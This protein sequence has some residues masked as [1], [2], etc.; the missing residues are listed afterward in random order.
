MFYKMF[1][2]ED[3]RSSLSEY[4]ALSILEWDVLVAS[5]RSFEQLFHAAFRTSEDF[6]VKGSNLEGTSFHSSAE[7]TDMWHVLGHINGNAIYN[8]NDPAFVEYVEYTRAR[9]QYDH[10]YDVALW[11]TIADFPYSWPLYQRYSKKFVVTNLISY[12]GNEHVTQATVSDAVAGQTLFIHGKRVDGATVPA[13]AKAGS[14]NIV[15]DKRRVKRDR[16]RRH[17]RRRRRLAAAASVATAEKGAGQPVAACSSHCGA[18]SDNRGLLPAGTSTVCDATC[19]ADGAGNVGSFSGLLCGAGDPKRFGSACR[20]CYVDL[21]E[22]REAER[23]GPR[24]SSLTFFGAESHVQPPPQQQHVVMCDTMRP[25]E[26]KRSEENAGRG[27][28]EGVPPLCSDECS[29]RNTVCDSSCGTGLYGDY[30]CGWKNRG[31]GCRYC[32]DDLEAAL[33]ADQVAAE[34]GGRVIMC[35]TLAPPSTERG[36]SADNARVVRGQGLPKWMTDEAWKTTKSEAVPFYCRRHAYVQSSSKVFTERW[37]DVLYEATLFK[38]K[39]VNSTKGIPSEAYT[40]SQRAFVGFPVQWPDDP[41]FEHLICFTDYFCPLAFCVV[42]VR[43]IEKDGRHTLLP[44]CKVRLHIRPFR[45]VPG[46]V[47]PRC[48][49]RPDAFCSP[50]P[51]FTRSRCDTGCER[52]SLDG[53]RGRVCD[54][55]CSDPSVYGT[56]GCSA[57]QGSFGA[58]C[59]ACYNDVDLALAQDTP[60][61]RAIMCSTVLPVDVYARRL[62]ATTADDSPRRVARKLATWSEDKAGA[63]N[64]RKPQKKWRVEE[65]SQPGET[66][67]RVGATMLCTPAPKTW[68][69][70]TT[71]SQ[72]VSMSV[73]FCDN[74]CE[75]T[76]ADGARGRVCDPNCS[77]PD[78]YGTLGCSA[79][80]GAFGPECRACFNDDDLALAQDTPDDRAIMCSTV[81]PVDIYARRL[82]ATTAGAESA[83]RV[84]QMLD[85]ATSA[86]A[87]RRV[88]DLVAAPTADAGGPIPADQ[89]L[90]FFDEAAGRPYTQD[91]ARGNL[92]G[93][94]AGR[95]G[96]AEMWEVTVKSILEFVPG[97]RV[98]VA[99]EVE[100]LAEYERLMGG[101]PGVTVSSTQDA[102]AASLFADQYCGPGTSLV[103]Y[104]K[105]GSILSRS[106]TSKDTHSPEGDLLVV[107]SD[108]RGSNHASELGRRTALV[109]GSEAPSFTHGT[110]LMLPASINEDLRTILGLGSGDLTEEEQ[111]D[112]AA[113]V[114]GLQDMIGFDEVS[115]VPQVSHLCVLAAFAYSRSTPGLWF[116]DPQGWLSQHLFKEVPIW[117]IPLVKPRYTCAIPP[118]LLD[119]GNQDIADVLRDNLDFFARGG[120][121]E[122]GLIDMV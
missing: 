48:L 117:A 114:L 23:R 122:N 116:L 18:G 110:D 64:G 22:A 95:A 30:N 33:L 4:D 66:N 28:D 72:E 104:L 19:V 26:A 24:K 40:L 81:L 109:L 67:H 6:W 27:T 58:E 91:L 21:D 59:R 45:S 10:P 5:D 52:T 8:N 60:E 3:V 62:S 112:A 83:P 20:L 68:H 17:R 85:G 89:T 57:G 103:L 74:D 87:G 93:F 88:N 2:D 41:Q 79:G 94:V 82:S 42:S 120:K 37:V 65:E 1:L 71:Q 63:R 32:F 113:V 25:P 13:A 86:T 118:A 73:V 38:E 107:Y 51:P 115:A 96:D 12:V 119:T 97:M 56:L 106:F 90:A 14:S 54:P 105:P 49:T 101:L 102:P 39:E 76:S 7:M 36:T 69:L 31:S 55:N 99:A 84:A 61:D 46:P 15:A 34:H 50:S 16:K 100:G 121:C 11:L 78:V 43:R 47:R 77:D 98:A 35:S 53:T 80:Q 108:A 44:R 75:G 111:N 70:P 9:W 92:C 29:G